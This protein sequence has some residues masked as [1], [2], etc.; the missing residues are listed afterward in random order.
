[1]WCVS[2]IVVVTGVVVFILVCPSCSKLLLSQFFVV[3]FIVVFVG[4]IVAVVVVVV[5]VAVE[6]FLT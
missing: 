5:F 2:C 6:Y 1:M 3:Y 4:V